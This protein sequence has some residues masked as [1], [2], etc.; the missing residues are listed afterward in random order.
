MI[1]LA[2]LLPYKMASYFS[3]VTIFIVPHPVV[4]PV[5]TGYASTSL[6]TL[7][8][9]NRLLSTMFEWKKFNFEYFFSGAD[10]N[11][12]IDLC[13]EESMKCR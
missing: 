11:V 6:Q 9:N 8:A 13:G 3:R 10:F 7:M 4:Q 12:F 5:Y 2:F 1:N